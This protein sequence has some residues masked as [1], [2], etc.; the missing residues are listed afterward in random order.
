MRVQANMVW[1]YA[2]NGHNPGEAFLEAL[3]SH[4]WRTLPA[5]SPQN[6]SN[7]VWAL[8]TLA[9]HSP[10]PPPSLSPCNAPIVQAAT[11]MLSGVR[12]DDDCLPCCAGAQNIALG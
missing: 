8:A 10:V 9:F 6:I 2:T 1:A 4:A 11:K 12:V 3:A 5:F 7:T